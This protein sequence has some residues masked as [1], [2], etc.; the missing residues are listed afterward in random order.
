MTT[1]KPEPKRADWRQVKARG[2]HTLMDLRSGEMRRLKS[3][4]KRKSVNGLEEC[5]YLNSALL[6][7]GHAMGLNALSTVATGSAMVQRSDLLLTV[8][9]RVCSGRRSWSMPS[10]H[11]S[12]V[13]WLSRNL[14]EQ[15]AAGI[16]TSWRM[17]VVY[18]GKTCAQRGWPVLDMPS[19]L[20][21]AQRLSS[22][23]NTVDS[24]RDLSLLPIIDRPWN[25]SLRQ[26]ATSQKTF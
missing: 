8:E 14:E 11:T 1:V 16:S 18:D 5:I 15:T 7:F 22:G 23:G 24:Y 3:V 10:V 21:V 20:R 4:C 12:A 26:L 9:C 25:T 6:L 2:A 17:E 19:A 13:E